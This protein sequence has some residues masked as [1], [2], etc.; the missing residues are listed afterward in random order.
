MRDP[1]FTITS[2]DLALFTDFYELT[3]LQS[4]FEAGYSKDAV[5]SLFVRRLPEHRN[6]LL[7]CGLADVLECLESLRFSAEA[8]TYLKSLGKFSDSFLNWLFNF[9]FEGDVHAVPEGTPVF[10][11]EPILEVVAP[12]SQAQVIETLVM[13]Q[14]HLQTLLASKATRVVKAAAG[15]AVIDFGARRMHGFDAAL[16]AARAFHIAGVDA[17]SNVLAGERYG[18]PVTGTMAHSYIQAFDSEYEA[19]RE[20]VRCYPKTILLVDTYD[21]IEGVKNVIKLARELG[22]K[23][24]VQGV[25]LDSGNLTGL[26]KESRRLLDAAGLD[27]VGIVA[28][29]GL[30][31]YAIAGLLRNGAPVN[32]FGVGTSMGVSQDL[33]ALD[34]AYKLCA[35]DGEGR[36]KLSPGK[37][38]YPGRKQIFRFEKEGEAIYDVISRAEEDLPGRPL[39]K[40]VMQG[41]KRLL[42]VPQ[43]LDE[44]RSFAQEQIEIL[45]KTIN[46]IDRPPEP[47]PVHVSD[48]LD[49][50]RNEVIAKLQ[51]ETPRGSSS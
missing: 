30:D 33:P 50:Y 15:R 31:E 11:N 24:Q 20:F 45:P 8:I 17:T 1:A 21:T 29:S 9:R 48:R 28:S 26:A 40:P 49:G 16:R 4:Y 41:G 6:F 39:L 44:I 7:A 32:G 2:D 25:R 42:D 12:I 35:Y 46:S 5:F 13:N 14:I 3:M 18:V 23:F 51:Q 22:D 27:T 43:N 47:Y 37:Q 10:A 36:L 34:I 38:T 19:F